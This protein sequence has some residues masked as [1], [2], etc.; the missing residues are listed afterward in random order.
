MS[1]PDGYFRGTG[2]VVDSPGFR[3]QAA[4]RPRLALV[5]APDW[6]LFADAPYDGPEDAE[7]LEHGEPARG[8]GETIRPA[9]AWISAAELRDEVFPPVEW[10]I[11]GY[12]PAGL[13]LL[14]GRPKL[15]KSWLAL[16]WCV[17][18]ARGGYSMSSDYAC[19]T[20]D[21]LYMALEDTARRLQARLRKVLGSNAEWPSRIS[22]S[23]NLPASDPQGLATVESWLRQAKSSRLIVVDTLAK[24]RPARGRGDDPYASDY[25]AVAPWKT[26]AD[27]HGV[28]VVLVHHVRKMGAEDPLEM[29]SGTN[30]L[31]GAADTIMVLNRDGQGCTLTGRGRDLEEFER[32]VRFDKDSCRWAVLG[33]ASEVRRSDER[34]AVMRHLADAG[35]DGLTPAELRD[36]SDLT[37]AHAKKILQRMVKAGEADRGLQRRGSYVVRG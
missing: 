1:L 29:V 22:L 14:A 4:R 10:I 36:L 25:S 18:V 27:A 33:E 34:N 30:G 26:L 37:H 11:P 20:G 13:T 35:A 15:G 21:V 16:D 31:T 3:R 17:A 12:L 9:A 5:D 8:D 23:A 2:S 19:L 28:A 7:D 32:A 6:L 24:V